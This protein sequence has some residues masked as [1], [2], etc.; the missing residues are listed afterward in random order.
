MAAM[1]RRLSWALSAGYVGFFLPAGVLLS[2]L[3]PFLAAKGLTVVQMSLTFSAVFAVKL[4]IGPALAWWGDRARQQRLLMTITAW[5]SAGAA[6]A[7]A[8]SD[9][10]TV[11]LAA[12]IVIAVCRNYLQCMLEALAI[13]LEDAGGEPRYG[14]MRAIGSAAVCGGIV[15]LGGLWSA[16]W[17]Y[18]QTAL[19]AIIFASGSI[20]IAC[21]RAFAEPGESAGTAPRQTVSTQE[22]GSVQTLSAVLLITGATLLI[23]A[24]GV[25]YATASL[26]MSLHGVSPSNIALLW[27]LAFGIEAVGFAAF[28]HLR[29]WLGGQAFFFIAVSLALLRW[30]L[31]AEGASLAWQVL[32]FSLHVA[33]FSWVH[34]FCANWVRD[35]GTKRFAVTA[36]AV[37]TACAHGIGM[38][39]TAY[40]AG[41]LRAVMGNSVYWIA[42]VMSCAGALLLTL[43]TSMSSPRFQPNADTP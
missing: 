10:F 11:V 37:Y 4:I 13:Q 33:S 6:V 36:Q 12:A 39:C 15:L 7:L 22:K 1:I 29:K 34:A 28:E 30:I 41:V 24:N 5:A 42:A 31:F 21:L 3:P 18:Q 35:A 40:A 19:P 32:A 2:Y 43:R 20:L 23:G 16:P 9:T 38:A 26:T 25:F 27:C 17:S 14:L 8:F